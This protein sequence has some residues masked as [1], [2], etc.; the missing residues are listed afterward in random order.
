MKAYEDALTLLDDVARIGTRNGDTYLQV[1]ERTARCRINLLLRDVVSASRTMDVLWDHVAS[2]GQYAEFLACRA[3]ALGMLQKGKEDPFS[4]L[5]EAERRSRE[6]EATLLCGCVR[7]LLTLDRDASSAATTIADAFRIG[8]AKGVVDPFVFAFRVDDR[9]A[10]LLGQ[11]ED[12]RPALTDLMAIV[13][14]SGLEQ[15]PVLRRPN[16]FENADTLTNRER[17]V[18]EFVA[19]GKTNLEIATRLFLTPGTVKVHVRNILRKLNVRSRTEAAIYAVKMQQYEVEAHESQ[20][21]GLSR[22]DSR[23]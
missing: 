6:N 19:E 20:T 12:L 17:E 3:L 13:D 4:V 11:D 21:R 2:S 8:M 23:L 16:P 5:A 10:S 14:A 15:R 9:L 18:L 1:S 22:P 7:A